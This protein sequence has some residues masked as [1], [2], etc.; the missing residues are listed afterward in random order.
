MTRVMLC[1]TRKEE[2]ISLLSQAGA[3]AIGLITEVWQNIPCKLS[4]DRARELSRLIPPF[5]SSVLILTE[6]RMDE[7]C[8][9][10]EHVLPD[11]LQLHGMNTPQDVAILKERLGIKIVKT[12]HFQGERMAEGDDP[13]STAK[14]FISAGAG[15]IL[16]DSY[17]SDKVGA[18]GELVSLSLARRL[19]DAIYPIPL[20]L[21]GGLN[22][23]NVTYAI[24]EVK[25]FAVDVFSGVTT[26]GYLDAGRVME[27]TRRVRS[28]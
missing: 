25:P 15:A 10:S 12:L 20:I 27:F 14:Q 9:I 18:T 4:R 6:E 3:D 24:E 17:K 5:V 1:G 7:I 28:G 19:R 11:V 22:S 21:A 23:D 16:V 8:R 13:L 26:D 2:D